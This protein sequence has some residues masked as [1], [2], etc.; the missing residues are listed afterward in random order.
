MMWKIP[1][2]T[3]RI[4]A[5]AISPTAP[6]L[7]SRWPVV[8]PV[9]VVAIVVS[10]ASCASHDVTRME[11]L[12]ILGLSAPAAWAPHPRGVRR[13]RLVPRLLSKDWPSAFPKP[14]FLGHA[15]SLP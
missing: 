9:V 2:R 13:H 14:V 6:P 15:G 5:K 10:V 12:A 11:L 7:Y 8:G 3:M 1:P 4:P